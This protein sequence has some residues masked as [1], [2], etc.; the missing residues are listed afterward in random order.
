MAVKRGKDGLG[1]G[2]P[3]RHVLLVFVLLAGTAVVSG[4]TVRLGFETHCTSRSDVWTGSE[5]RDDEKV[6]AFRP[7]VEFE[8]GNRWEPS[9]K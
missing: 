8:D 2:G 5:R 1:I 6:C 3:V 4:N 9:Y 7:L